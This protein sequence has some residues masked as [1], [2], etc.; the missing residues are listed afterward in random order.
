MTNSKAQMTN[1]YRNSK[2]KTQK[3][4]LKLKTKKLLVLSC[5]FEV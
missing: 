1:Q 5:G 4:K 2:R 3:S